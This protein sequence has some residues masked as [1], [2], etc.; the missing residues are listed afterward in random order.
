MRLSWHRWS[1]HAGWLKASNEDLARWL[2]SNDPG[3]IVLDEV[4]QDGAEWPTEKAWIE[5]FSDLGIYNKTG[6]PAWSR[7]RRGGPLPAPERAAV[8]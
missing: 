3:A 6:N 2:D 1:R 7:K 5:K 8:A 4:T